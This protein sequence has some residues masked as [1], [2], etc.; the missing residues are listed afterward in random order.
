[1]YSPP[2]FM[3]STPSVIV[4]TRNTQEEN[5]GQSSTG[6]TANESGP[7]VSFVS[8]SKGEPKC[9]GLNF[10]TLITQS[11]NGADV[12]VPLES[13]CVVSERYVNSAYGF[14]LGKWVA[15][16]VVANYVRNTWGKYGL[17]LDMNL[18][19]EDVVNVPVWVKIH[20]VPVTTF[21]EDGLS[22]IAT[23]IGTHLMLDSYTSDMCIQSWGRSSYARAMIEIRDDVELKDTIVVA[24]LK[25]TREGF[26]TCTIRVEYEW[27]PPRCTCCKLFG[28]IQEECPK[29]PGLGVAKN[30]KKPSLAPRGVLVSSKVG[31]KP[32]KEYRHIAKKPTANTIGI[33]KKGVEPTKEVTNS[34]PFNVLNS[35]VNNEVLGTNGG[36]QIWLV[37]GP[38]VDKIRKLEKIII[39]EKVTL[40]DDDGKPLKKVDYPGDH[41]SNDEVC[42]VDNDM[43]RSMA[44]KTV[45]F[46]TK[47]LLEQWTDSYVNDDYDEDPYD[48]DM[49]EGQV[50]PDKLQDICDNLDIRVRGQGN[51]I[52]F[53]KRKIPKRWR[54]L[55]VVQGMDKGEGNMWK[56]RRGLNS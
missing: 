34:N 48:D 42:S 39:E 8:L 35:V 32:T 52:L 19:K 46:G 33:K 43:A 31:F 10:H 38:I 22:A 13:I 12:F 1:M 26:Y 47:S 18:M 24:M 9:K 17:N 6:P 27:K 21:T 53:E 54:V 49:Y 2:P 29:N 37:T 41:D 15:Y 16:P 5:V 7:D 30:L 45:G 23:K 4:A 3:F 36:L 14:F 55:H 50:L 20:G 44:T 40:V 28:H 56:T 51:D 25:L 11:G